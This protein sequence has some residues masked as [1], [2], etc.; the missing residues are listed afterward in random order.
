VKALPAA[1]LGKRAQA[2]LVQQNATADL[3][4]PRVM[5]RNTSASQVLDRSSDNQQPE[6]RL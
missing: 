4:L 6:E 5:Y 3:V 1:R 2:N